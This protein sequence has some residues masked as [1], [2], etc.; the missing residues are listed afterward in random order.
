[1]MPPDKVADGE[2]QEQARAGERMVSAVLAET[3][4]L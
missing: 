2:M 3:K 4:G 1:M